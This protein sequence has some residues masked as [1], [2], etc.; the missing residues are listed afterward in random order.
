MAY[1]TNYNYSKLCNSLNLKIEINKKT[2]LKLVYDD[3]DVFN[4][5][6]KQELEYLFK[7]K[8][9][10]DDEKEFWTDYY[11]EVPPN[12]DTETLV[13]ENEDK[14]KY[15]L[16]NDCIALQMDY[17]NVF[18][19]DDIQ[20]YANSHKDPSS[21]IDEFRDWFKSNYFLQRY[22]QGKISK[23][24]I[25]FEYNSKYPRKY[26]LNPI[27]DPDSGILFIHK[28]NNKE[29]VE[30]EREFNYKEFLEQ[31]EEA[32]KQ[33]NNAFS[34]PVIRT[35]VKFRYILNKSDNE[36]QDIFDRVFNV[37]FTKKLGVKTI[38]EKI[39]LAKEHTTTIFQLLQ[40]YFK[41]KYNFHEKNFD[42][43]TLD[44]FNLACCGYC[45]KRARE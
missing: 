16:F 20:E 27:T 19:P 37:G 5:L 35:L 31:L 1:L 11:Q 41:W 30:L 26:G 33:Y 21:I 45:S 14:I 22:L 17:D 38:K 24:S 15:H 3:V 18:I 40:N 42:I 29:V 2:F 23:A 39:T 9:I 6:N 44:H 7:Y 25:I 36:I 32:K 8:S 4:I 28:P 13:F 12:T 43:I 10:L 34:G